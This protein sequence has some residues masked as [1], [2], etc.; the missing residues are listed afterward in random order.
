M[1]GF[2]ALGLRLHERLQ[3]AADQRLHHRVLGAEGLQ[4]DGARSLRTTGTAGDLVQQLHG[5]LG[6]AQVT[7]GQAEVGIH[8][9][10]QRQMRE[11]PALG[12]DLRA[13][14]QIDLAPLDRVRGLGG[15]VW[16]VFTKLLAGLARE[17]KA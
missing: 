16:G 5:P 13:D 2:A 12:D 9:A 15:G 3:V 14:D 4:Q 7:T 8:H 17:G 1:A 10:D 11:V 6:G